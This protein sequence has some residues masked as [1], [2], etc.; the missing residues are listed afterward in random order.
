VYELVPQ[1]GP[2]EPWDT[3]PPL[4]DWP[5][6]HALQLVSFA[7]FIVVFVAHVILQSLTLSWSV[8]VVVFGVV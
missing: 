2:V 4:L 7:S 5:V 6:G 1:A 3:A 8:D